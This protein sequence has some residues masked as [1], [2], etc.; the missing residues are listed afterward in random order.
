VISN[1]SNDEDDRQELWL[2]V[3][4][5]I[6]LCCLNKQLKQINEEKRIRDSI[7]RVIDVVNPKADNEFWDSFTDLERD[8]MLYF[9]LDFTFSDIAAM[10]GLSKNRVSCIIRGIKKNDAWKKME[11]RHA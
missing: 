11:K 9:V 1:L 7:G 10:R 4:E 8:I 3:L 2:C 5:G 6:P